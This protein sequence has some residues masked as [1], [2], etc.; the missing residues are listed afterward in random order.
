MKG[1]LFASFCHYSK[2]F[3]VNV[4]KVRYNS[5]M[6]KV[7]VTDILSQ[8]QLKQTKAR[9]ALVEVL[10]NEHEPIDAAH[11]MMLLSEKGVRVDQATVYRIL[12][13][14]QKKGIITRFELQEGKFRYELSRSNE[15]HH[16]ICEVCSKI[17]D[18]SDCN[19][20]ALE[21]EILQKKGFHVNRHTLEFF[22]VCSNCFKKKRD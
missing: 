10:D 1:V 11:L 4:D 20:T 15:H 7:N 18:I 2:R 3:F 19:I 12:D 6:K 22:G 14:F 13:V 8:A 9:I 21:E 16:L 5:E 17:E